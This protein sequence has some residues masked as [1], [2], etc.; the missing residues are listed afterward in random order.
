MLEAA[1]RMGVNV[2]LVMDRDRP[3]PEVVLDKLILPDL[4]Q[5]PVQWAET[6]ATYGRRWGVDGVFTHEDELVELS[7]IVAQYLRLPGPSPKGVRRALDKWETRECLREIGLPNPNYRRANSFDEL[8]SAVNQIGLPVVIKPIASSS[9]EGASKVERLEDIEI[10]WRAAFEASLSSPVSPG[11][12]I[13]EEYLRD[14]GRVLS[15][16]GMIIEGQLFPITITE[17]HQ[18]HSSRGGRALRIH[19]KDYF[20]PAPV[21][22]KTYREIV[23]MS[24]KLAEALPIHLGAV[25]VEYKLTPEGPRLLEF[26]PRLGGG[27]VPLMVR[28]AFG[29]DLAEASLKLALGEKPDLRFT[30]SSAVCLDW[31]VPPYEGIVR[32]VHGFEEM[33]TAPNVV[34]GE[35]RVKIGERVAPGW[36][37]LAFVMTEHSDPLGALKSARNA[38]K[39]LSIEIEP[40]S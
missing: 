16:E 23:L 29:V 22:E 8:K 28:Q 24:S 17:A 11:Q 5:N 20:L 4:Y 18:Y 1:A 21:T 39:H 25:H 36:L 19:Y 6:I 30:K 3:T 7:A 12:V 26:N 2:L 10:A 14:E 31:Y 35:L 33:L 40:V 27:L 13:V 32:S 9:A 15:L 34:H 37:G 38:L